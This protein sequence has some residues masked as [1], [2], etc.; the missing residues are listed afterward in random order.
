[1]SELHG[2]TAIVTGGGQGIGRE[3]ALALAAGGAA[4]VL[5]G[6]TASTL[7]S[8]VAEVEHHGGK[9]LAVVADVA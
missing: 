9:A 6:R 1:M 2:Q 7:A 4:V 3:I 5:T 8:V